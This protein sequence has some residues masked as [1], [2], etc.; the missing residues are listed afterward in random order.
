VTPPA[1]PSHAIAHVVILLQE[2]RSFDNLFAGFPGANTTM[3]GLC[4]AGPPW[5]KVAREVPLK[6]IPLAEG[7][8]GLGGK[9]ICHSHQCFALECDPDAAHVCR[10]DGFD[11]IDFGESQGGPSAKLYPYSYVRHSDV[12]AYWKL[13]KQYALADEMFFTETAASFVA[14]QTILSGTARLNDR[15]SLTD[16]PDAM[17]WGCDAPVGTA[18]AVIFTDG[19][20]SEFGGPFPCF[21]QYRT[22]ADLLDAAGVSWRY[23]VDSFHVSYPDLSSYAWNGF[24]AIEQVRFGPDW[25]H[26]ISSP[27]AN[28]FND[29]QAGT[30]PAVSWVIPLLNDSDHPASG[31]DGGPRWVAKIVNAIGTSRYWES[32]AIVLLWDDWGGWYDNVKPPQITYTRLGFR[33]PMVV[34]SPFA[35][36]HTVSHTRYTFG[37]VLKFVEQTFGLGSLGTSDASSNSISDVFDFAQPPI[38]FSPAPLPHARACAGA[39]PKNL[40]RIVKQDGG[41]PD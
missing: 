9:D 14:H 25:K 12:A 23:Y 28:I 34:I 31:C 40:A 7:P 3:Q 4:K 19:R 10:N 26:D 30:L 36:P 27:N 20:V 35:K 16:Q 21:N 24:D 29:V 32:T 2:N 41:P 15:E 38:A 11:L 33:V 18:S 17:P 8:A 22:M 13:A 1:A 39:T 5:C 37:S 6:P